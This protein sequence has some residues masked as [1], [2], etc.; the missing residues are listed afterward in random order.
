MCYNFFRVLLITACTALLTVWTCTV[1]NTENEVTWVEIDGTTYG[2]RADDRGPIGGGAGYTNMVTHGDYS[3]E[4]LDESME[5]VKQ[6][7]G[8]VTLPK[9]PIPGIG[10]FTYCKDPE[11][12][13][14]G[15]LQ[16]DMNAK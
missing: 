10:W 11:G 6:A 2:A 9:T 4:N 1:G 13:L 16:S 7:G 15:I 5:K 14:F 12:N 8:E 3:V